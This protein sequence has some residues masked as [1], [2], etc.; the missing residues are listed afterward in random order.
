MNTISLIGNLVKDPEARKSGSGMDITALRIAVNAGRKDDSK[1]LYLNVDTF[2]ALA[3]TALVH[4]KKGD[5]VGITG[6]LYLDTYKAKD[7]TTRERYYVIANS[8]DF[9]SPKND[10]KSDDGGMVSAK[11]GSPDVDVIPDDDLPF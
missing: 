2:K 11:V 3:T 7:G 6:T 10:G 5:K 8:L 4:L 9:L 1:T